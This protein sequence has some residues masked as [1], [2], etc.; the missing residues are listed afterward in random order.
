MELQSQ[1]ST[2]AQRIQKSAQELADDRGNQGEALAREQRQCLRDFSRK[3][4]MASEEFHLDDTNRNN[5]DFDKLVQDDILIKSLESDSVSYVFGGP[6]C[7]S[8]AS[9]PG[10]VLLSAEEFISE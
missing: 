5:A 8:S 1:P 10:V 6:R 3:I 7:A 4:W 9:R 2:E